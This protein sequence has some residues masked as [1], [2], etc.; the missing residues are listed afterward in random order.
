MRH[1]ADDH[2]PGETDDHFLGAGEPNIVGTWTWDA[3][4]GLHVLDSGAAEFLTGDQS[5]AETKLTCAEVV[6]RIHPDDRASVIREIARA[7]QEGGPVV[8]TYRVHTEDGV[9]WL[10]DHGRIYATT[11]AAPAHGHGILI[12]VTQRMNRGGEPGTSSAERLSPLDRAARHAIAARKAIDEDGTPLLRKMVDLLMWEI[13][14]A[15]ARRIDRASGGR[16]N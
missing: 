5:L 2:A 10:L 9:R 14:R 7:E 13:G 11:Q 6:A 15:I 4:D 3:A 16:L 8:L 12:D 1:R